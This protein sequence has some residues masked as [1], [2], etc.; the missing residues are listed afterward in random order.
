MK[1]VNGNLNKIPKSSTL[2]FE[3]I[4]TNDS[5]VKYESNNTSEYYYKLHRTKVNVSLILNIIFF[6]DNQSS[7]LLKTNLVSK[8]ELN[9]TGQKKVEHKKTHLNENKSMDFL[10]FVFILYKI[11]ILCFFSRFF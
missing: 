10:F 8:K 2:T 3:N 1:H 11:L 6:L 9:I 7:C 4:F 5:P